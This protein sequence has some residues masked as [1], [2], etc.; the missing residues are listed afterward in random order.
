MGGNPAILAIDPAN[1]SK[2]YAVAGGEL[3]VSRD[4]GAKWS[5]TGNNRIVALAVHPSDSRTLFAADVSG[6][7]LR[8]TDGGVFFDRVFTGAGHVN[9]LVIDPK[10]P[11][12][13]YVGSSSS[14]PMDGLIKSA[15]G[16]ATWKP[17]AL[18]G[19]GAAVF[20]VGIAPSRPST[21]MSAT[22]RGEF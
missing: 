7:I 15:D 6:S 14:G 1:P 21:R 9:A 12:N 10:N 17:T 18:R 8:S 22:T 16:G 5:A 2:I 3:Y 4:S 19:S 11:L 20:A 13:I